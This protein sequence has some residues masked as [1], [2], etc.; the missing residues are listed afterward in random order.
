MQKKILILSEAFGSGHTK[1]A[2]AL[3]QA[4]SLQEP[5]VHIEIIEIGRKLHPI[6]SSL[7]FHI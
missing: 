6:A 5:S 4:I 7:I 1:A 2:E 3:V